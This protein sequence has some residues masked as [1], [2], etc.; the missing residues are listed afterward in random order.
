[1]ASLLFRLR[2]RYWK[3]NAPRQIGA[4]IKRSE[5]RKLQIG[6]GSNVLDGWLNSTLY[7]FVPGTVFLDASQP[8]PISTG[9]FDYIFSEH[10]IEHLEFAEAETMLREGFRI[11]KPAG[12]IRLATPDLGADHRALR[13]SR[14]GCS[15]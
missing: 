11:L 7:P 3:W 15:K 9:S 8:F 2:K 14:S 10:V 1:M 12:R 4:Y 5:D 13:N 6:T